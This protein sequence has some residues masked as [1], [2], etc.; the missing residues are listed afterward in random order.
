[1][2]VAGQNISSP[3]PVSEHPAPLDDFAVEPQTRVNLLLAQGDT[4]AAIDILHDNCGN[5]WSDS[6]LDLLVL[7]DLVPV[8]KRSRNA[9]TKNEF[10]L[11]LDLGMIPDDSNLTWFGITRV[12]W[13]R[14]TS[15]NDFHAEWGCGLNV[16]GLHAPTLDYAGLEPTL[17]GTLRSGRAQVSTQA[18]MRFGNLLGSDAGL[19]AELLYLASP[20]DLAGVV[21][22]LSLESTQE[23]SLV[24]STERRTGPVAWTTSIFAGW[25]RMI[26]PPPHGFHAMEF[27][28]V[29]ISQATN[30][31]YYVDDAWSGG[32]RYNYRNL[33]GHVDN[34]NWDI[35]SLELDR[36]RLRTR[37]QA[38]LGKRDLQYG[39]TIDAQFRSSLNPERWLPDARS[40]W[41]PGTSF[42]RVRGTS[43]VEAYGGRGD[44]MLTIRTPP[45]IEAVYFSTLLSPGFRCVLRAPGDVWQVE[46]KAIWNIA[47]A[48][49]KGHPFA[50]TRKGA[51]LRASLQQIW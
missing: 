38:M 28:S 4:L 31:S 40:T 12:D 23:A 19:D 50:E 41:A 37:I 30:G 42:L 51:E 32:T 2:A 26:P 33:A 16:L 3:I 6:L 34:S 13:S 8:A 45:L 36:L 49:D 48:S 5:G 39:P 7:P 24:A 1:M 27:D 43:R 25:I 46:G 15:R 20:S 11:R 47:L 17:D 14:Y 44:S 18:W 22:S 29:A 9:T 10:R 35:E 21:L